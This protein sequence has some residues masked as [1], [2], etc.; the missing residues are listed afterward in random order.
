VKVTYESYINKL[1]KGTAWG[2][3]PGPLEVLSTT[4]FKIRE[5]SI[6][7]DFP[8]GILD[9]LHAKSFSIAAVGQNLYLNAKQFK[10]S[11]PDGGTENF[12]DPSQRFIGV[13]VKA[14]F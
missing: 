7:Y 10:Y 3:A 12:S 14:S 4:F 13:N 1:H 11:D 9:I 6:N 2:G 5:M 8:K